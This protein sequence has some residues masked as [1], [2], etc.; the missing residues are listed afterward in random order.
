[1]LFIRKKDLN[2]INKYY[3]VIEYLIRKF[4]VNSNTIFTLKTISQ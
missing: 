2:D 3:D 1:M 4:Y